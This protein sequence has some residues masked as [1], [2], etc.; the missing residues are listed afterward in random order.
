MEE[1]VERLLEELSLEKIA[2]EVRA[3]RRP[4]QYSAPHIAAAATIVA[5]VISVC[6]AAA[7]GLFDVTRRELE[8]RKAELRLEMA[9]IEVKRDALSRTF[10]QEQQKYQREIDNLRKKVE[11]LDVPVISGAYVSSAPWSS[12]A[13]D[14]VLAVGGL[15]ID[16]GTEHSGKL[17]FSYDCDGALQPSPSADDWVPARQTTWRESRG[18]LTFYPAAVQDAIR[19]SLEKRRG[20]EHGV[21]RGISRIFLMLERRDGKVSSVFVLNDDAMKKWLNQ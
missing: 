6:W 15:N 10:L 13:D 11:A 4:W 5:A 18:Y 21:C 17:N 1:R 12:S 9:A 20:H 7:N 8:L 3:L 2:L 14:I 16:D 19:E